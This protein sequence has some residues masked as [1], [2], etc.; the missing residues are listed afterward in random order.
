MLPIE[1]WTATLLVDA[2]GQASPTDC[3]GF[4]SAFTTIQA[5]VN[6]ASPGD[7]IYICPGV[8][9][10]Q[11]RVTKSGLTIRG[12]GAGLTVLRPVAVIQNR[13]ALPYR[14]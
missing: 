14:H 2:D 5:A 3:N 11:I 8:Y 12:S 10:E 9:N 13:Q 4:G 6:A 1:G 7:T